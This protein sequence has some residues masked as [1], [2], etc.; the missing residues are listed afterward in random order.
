M[1]IAMWMGA[2]VLASSIPNFR[3]LVGVVV[4]L[5]VVQYTFTLPMFFVIAHLK[6]QQQLTWYQALHRRWW[7]TLFILA[8]LVATVLETYS[9]IHSMITDV[10]AG[11]TPMVFSC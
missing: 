2:F 4:S 8:A 10:Q 6:R 5:F 9:N 1:A 3:D 7:D 11:S